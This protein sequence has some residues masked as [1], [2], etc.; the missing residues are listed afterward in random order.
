MPLS[1]GHGWRMAEARVKA[2]LWVQ[3]AL[4]LGNAAGRYG[5]VLRKGDP[6]AGGVLVVLHG[7]LGMMVLS[8]SRGAEGEMVWLR[9]TGPDAVDQAAVDAYV[10]RQLGY[11]PDLWVLEFESP[12]LLPPFEGKIA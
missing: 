5:M 8:Q 6:D 2:G 12:D 9:A 1:T 3:A 4:R 11:D 10:Q 7:K